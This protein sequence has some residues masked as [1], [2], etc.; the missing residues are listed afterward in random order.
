MAAVSTTVWVTL[1][2]GKTTVGTDKIAGMMSD[3]ADLRKAVKTEFAEELTHCSAATL[4]VFK[5]DDS[6]DDEKNALEEDQLLKELLGSGAGAQKKSAFTVK[7][8]AGSLP[9]HPTFWRRSARRSRFP[10]V[11][12]TSLS[13]SGF[14][15]LRLSNLRSCT[16]L[17][18][19]PRTPSRLHNPHAL[20]LGRHQQL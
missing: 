19:V 13:C 14:S 5:H 6:H 12:H 11:P 15:S 17:L 2:V 20:P 9:F 4:K 1:L 8:P 7:A 10:R 3:V 18:R 16:P